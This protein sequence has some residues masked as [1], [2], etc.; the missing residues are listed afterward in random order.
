M[1]GVMPSVLRRAVLLVFAIGLSLLV[2]SC[3]D[4]LVSESS[5]HSV[6]V[7]P[8]AILLMAA[9]PHATTGDS[10]TLTSTATTVG[11]TQTNDTATATWSSSNTSVVTASSGGVVTAVTTTGGLTAIFT[12]KDGGVTSNNVNVITYTGAVPTTLNLTGTSGT[13]PPG[14]YQL[15]VTLGSGGQDVT[16]FVEWTSSNSSV[17]TVSATGLVT[18]LTSGTAGATATITATAHLGAPS[19]T[20]PPAPLTT[21]AT[22]TVG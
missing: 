16:N 21:T 6:R 3:D 15:K 20:T 7:T 22:F 1:R 17:A 10:F 5:I 11:G 13:L 2:A 9:V 12:A 19:G 14:N 18:V 4:F 8:H